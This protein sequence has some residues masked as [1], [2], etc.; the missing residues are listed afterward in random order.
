VQVTCPVSALSFQTQSLVPV[1]GT[2]FPML[3]PSWPWWI[4]HQV[5]FSKTSLPL[6]II[7]FCKNKTFCFSKAKLSITKTFCK[8]G[9]Q[10]EVI[11]FKEGNAGIG[12]AHNSYHLMHQASEKDFKRNE[13]VANAPGLALCYWWIRLGSAAIKI[14]TTAY[15]MFLRWWWWWSPCLFDIYLLF[16]F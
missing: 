13:E 6:C 1:R 4:H 2:F 9:I 11:I 7:I 5:L 15:L 14:E 8:T 3:N 12:L 10:R 16:V